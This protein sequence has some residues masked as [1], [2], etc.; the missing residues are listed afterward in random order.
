MTIRV[1]GAAM[2]AGARR[3]VRSWCMARMNGSKIS[4]RNAIDF[5]YA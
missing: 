4:E 1:R 2:V 3:N 5:S